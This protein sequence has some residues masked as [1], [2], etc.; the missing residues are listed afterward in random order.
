MEYT[1]GPREMPVLSAVVAL[2]EQSYMVT[3]SDIAE[4]TGLKLAEVARSLD[5]L[6][7]VYVDFRKTETGGDPTFWYVLKVTPEARQVVG[8]WP[9]AEGLVDQL[10]KA[11][12]DAAENEDDPERHYQL[13]QAAGLLDGGI[14][15]VAI[16]VAA[17]VTGPSTAGPPATGP[18][19]DAG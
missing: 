12:R 10:A 9:T 7:P 18:A 6:D 1:W 4:R 8:Q 14:R 3:V 5:A 16:Q 17:T 15:D 19:A 13:R 2:L 11:F